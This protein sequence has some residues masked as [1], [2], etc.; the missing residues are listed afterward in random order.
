MREARRKTL[1]FPPEQRVPVT[2]IHINPRE[3][4]M[5]AEAIETL[6]DKIGQAALKSLVRLC[7]EIKTA[8]SAQQEAACAAMRAKAKERWVDEFLDDAR[9]AP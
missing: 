1:G 3:P 5:N 6:G 2:P 9:A 4:S 7:P 8:T